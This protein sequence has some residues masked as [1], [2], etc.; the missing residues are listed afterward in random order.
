VLGRAFYA[1]SLLWKGA[2]VPLFT[3]AP[4]SEAIFS[5]PYLDFLAFFL[6]FL[7]FW[8]LGFISMHPQPHDFFLS[9]ILITSFPLVVIL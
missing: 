4:F 9:A 2:G 5:V 3:S 6:S 7:A 1:A 8:V